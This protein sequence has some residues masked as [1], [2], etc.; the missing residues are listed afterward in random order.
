MNLN[1]ASSSVTVNEESGSSVGAY[2]KSEENVTVTVNG[3]TKEVDNVKSEDDIKNVVNNSE[4]VA[5]VN[6]IKFTSLQAA[7]NKAVNGSKITVLEDIDLKLTVSLNNNVNV[8]L[9]LN[10]KTITNTIDLWDIPDTDSNNWSLIS[11][12]N[13]NLLITGNGSLKAKANDCYAVDIQNGATCTI[14]N[15]TFVGNIHAVYV[16]KGICNVK[17]GHYSIQQTFSASYPYEYV[18]NC[19]DANRKNGTAEMTVTGGTFEKFNPTDCKAE[20]DHTNFCPEGYKAVSS[21]I[22]STKDDLQYTVVKE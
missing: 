11:I 6:G 9:D 13:G 2:S 15:G 18:L 4:V 17:G 21:I 12:K 16:F 7:L 8:T 1:I 14:E 5:E 20:G 19:Y 3:T 10:G 22:P